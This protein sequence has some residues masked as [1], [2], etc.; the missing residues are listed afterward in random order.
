M[1]LIP[2]IILVQEKCSQELS[3]NNEGYFIDHNILA[4]LK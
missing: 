2:F 1:N 3:H 4:V